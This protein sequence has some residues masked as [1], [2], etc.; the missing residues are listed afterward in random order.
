MFGGTRRITPPAETEHE[1][2]H[3]KVDGLLS[4]AGI[5]WEQLMDLMGPEIDRRIDARLEERQDAKSR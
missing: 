4:L 3:R 2:L 1:R 5:T